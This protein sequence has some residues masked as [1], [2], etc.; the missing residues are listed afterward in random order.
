MNPKD[1]MRAAEKARI[2]RQ[3]KK[4]EAERDRVFAQLDQQK[5]LIFNLKMELYTNRLPNSEKELQEAKAEHT[6]WQTEKKKAMQKAKA[7]KAQWDKH[8]AC[9]QTEQ[10]AKEILKK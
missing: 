6:Q 10:K 7:E 4:I 9:D 3:R 5:Q 2:L 1:E 8:I